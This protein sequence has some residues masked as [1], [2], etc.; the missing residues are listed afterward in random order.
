MTYIEIVS[1][2]FTLIGAL[3]AVITLQ[4]VFIFI[5]GIFAKRKVFPV[6]T[7]KLRYG[8]VIAARNEERVI[9][10]LI[11]SIRKCN[12][13][14]EKLDIF[15]IAHNCTDETA[16]I[17]REN[18]AIVYEYDN[19]EE[20]TKG[21][22]LKH[23]FECI[24]KDYG[25]MSYDGFHVFDAD[26]VLDGEY[27]NKMT[28]A[29]L[30]YDRQCAIT[31]FRNAK[32]FGTNALTACYGLSYIGN[33][34]I[35]SNGRMVVSC[36]SRLLGSG[37]LV[38]SE[39]V[40]DGWNLVDLSDDTDFT[41]EQV[42]GG[43]KVMYCDEAMYYDEHPTTFKAMW[44][45][46]LRWSKG[47]LIIFKKRGKELLKNAFG[48]R[49]KKDKKV[50]PKQLRGSSIDLILATFPV[51]AVGFT[52]FVINL[53]FMSFAPLFGGNIAAMWIRWAIWSGGGL[54]LS[55]LGLMLCAIIYYIKERKRIPEVP[56]RTK[57]ASIFLWPIFTLLLT[58]LQIVAMFTK[59]LTWKP[60]VHSDTSS[61]ETFN[62]S[63]T[64]NVDN[65]IYEINKEK[66]K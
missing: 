41:A 36:S 27:F 19:P 28:D 15:V 14:Q 26:N 49:K 33:C 43:H 45:Q 9:E 24:N 23:I 47:A 51:G 44:R 8:I 16:Q 34:S 46:R 13:P 17:A 10:N 60:I 54:L 32:N 58:P 2:V 25:I 48:F 63:Q 1:L 18:G 61:F 37:F 50:E 65:E 6:R 39:M 3:L 4:Y 21:Y 57:V 62:S 31:S 64:V 53:I 38:S 35:E 7:E 56:L 40:K 42:L 29:F 59:K 66:N 20:R 55:C 22:A 12:Y 5:I 52:I 11:K 30:Y